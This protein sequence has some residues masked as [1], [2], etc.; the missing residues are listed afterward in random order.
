LQGLYDVMWCKLLGSYITGKLATPAEIV[1]TSWR[2][3]LRSKRAFFYLMLSI[4]YASKAQLVC[5]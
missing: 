4:R 3:V 5:D 1:I 2:P